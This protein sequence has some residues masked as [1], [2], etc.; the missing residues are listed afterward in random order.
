[1]ADRLRSL[2]GCLIIALVYGFGLVATGVFLGMQNRVVSQPALFEL[3][4]GY[5]GWFWVQ[6]EDPSCPDPGSRLVFRVIPIDDAGRGCTSA[7]SLRGWTIYHFEYVRPDGS[8]KATEA[9]LRVGFNSPQ[10]KQEAYFIG[11][12][13]ELNDVASWPRK[14]PRLGLKDPFDY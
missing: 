11:T 2:G 1:M 5:R 7:S 13:A 6:Y 12:E 9:V 10:D 14:R 8:R 3:P 4:H